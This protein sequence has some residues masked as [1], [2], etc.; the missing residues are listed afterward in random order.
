MGRLLLLLLLV[1]LL[2]VLLLLLL[3]LLLGDLGVGPG[4][5]VAFCSTRGA[6][7]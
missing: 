7:T 4:C 6:V 2:L 5:K 1:L 3:L